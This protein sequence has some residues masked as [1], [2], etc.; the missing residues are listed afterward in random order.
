MK[1]AALAW[2]SLVWDRRSLKVVGDFTPSGPRL[3]I[4][5]CR[6]SGDRRLTLVID[7]ALGAPCITY[8]A[9]SFCPDLDA[10]I[11]N[12]WG[13]ESGPDQP[14]PADLEAQTTVGFVDLA[15]GARSAI[16]LERYPGSVEIIGSWAD[17][18][19]YDAVIWTSLTSNFAAPEK[20]NEPFS[21]EAAIRYLDGL[22]KLSFA[23]A[24][25]YIWNAP[26]EVQ[27]PVRAAV[28]LR[29]PRG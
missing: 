3:P 10:A 27:T 2:G 23:R 18:S 28:D 17:A 12:L 19:G 26:A 4:E 25:H 20:A 11:R 13:R 1:I 24:L 22:D 16:A 5:F 7:E 6:V 14:L 15:A 21:V 8:Q 9:L 29:W